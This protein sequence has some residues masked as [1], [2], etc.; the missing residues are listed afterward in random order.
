MIKNRTSATCS[1]AFWFTRHSDS[2]LSNENS[3][4]LIAGQHLSLANFDWT[5]SLQFHTIDFVWS[6]FNSHFSSP[7]L[8]RT[9]AFSFH[10]LIFRR[11]R[12]RGCNRNERDVLD[13]VFH[14]AFLENTKP[15]QQF[16]SSRRSLLMEGTKRKRSRSLFTRP[17]GHRSSSNIETAHALFKERAKS[18]CLGLVRRKRRGKETPGLARLDLHCSETRSTRR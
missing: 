8:R 7:R 3:S 4:K 5:T 14:A 15:P 16:L 6:K 11:K 9:D 1:Q 10:L 2:I 18:D 12:S 13:L 17:W